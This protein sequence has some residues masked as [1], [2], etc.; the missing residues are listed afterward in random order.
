VSSGVGR[1]DPDMTIQRRH[2][3]RKCSLITAAGLAVVASV[4]LAVSNAGGASTNASTQR[5]PFADARLKIEYN[6]TDGD[7]GLQV[8]VD[9]EPWRQ[10]TITNPGGR[11]VVDVEAEDVIRD[12]GLTELFSES[13]EP[14]FDGFPFD[15]FK[16]LFP[17]GRYTFTG[18]T[19]EGQRLRSTFQFSHT[20]PDAPRIATPASGAVLGPDELVVEWAPVT[21]PAGVDVVAYQVLVVD[22][23]LPGATP[24]ASWTSWSPRRCTVSRCRPSSWR[25][26]PTRPRSSPSTVPV[27]R[28]SPRWR[29]RSG[30]DHGPDPH[31]G[32]FSEG[33]GVIGH[34]PLGTRAWLPNHPPVRVDPRE[35]RSQC[36]VLLAP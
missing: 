30:S 20:V 15:E 10:I 12:Y 31:R 36:R 27:I 16:R 28:P 4:T 3:M 7:A 26:G 11:E 24:S 1:N 23:A 32:W 2:T 17:E 8:F 19:V 9:A 25:R 6:A 29:S 14:P 5:I 21:T 13:S 18:L 33:S 22:D 34:G 35:G